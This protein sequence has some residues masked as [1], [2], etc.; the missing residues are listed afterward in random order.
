M[1]PK[2]T[3]RL[4]KTEQGADLVIERVFR[5]TLDDVWRSVTSSESTARWFGPWEGEP[6]VGNTIRVQMVFEE[7][8]PWCNARIDAC[9][10]PHRLGFYMK[11]DHGEW[12]LQLDL[13]ARGDETVLTFVQRL[14]KPSEAAST[15]P[16][17]EYYLDMLGAAYRGEAL[18]AFAD[19]YPSQKE[20]YAAAA[21]AIAGE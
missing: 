12:T 9:D 5:G 17:W 3:G 20:H 8:K 6:G 1:S 18:P 15:G 13:A 21:R 7:G 16:G 19:Y 11:D 2:P 14:K 10:P 4:D